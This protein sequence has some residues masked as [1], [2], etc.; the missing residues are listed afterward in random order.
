ML[1]VVSVQTTLRHLFNFLPSVT[2]RYLQGL[3]RKIGEMLR[4][5]M[6]RNFCR[7]AIGT[8]CRIPGEIATRSNYFY[9]T[10]VIPIMKCDVLPLPR[11]ASLSLSESI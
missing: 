3:H 4:L 1:Y 8:L 2:R 11:D 6:I 7:N 5:F 9:R 10:L